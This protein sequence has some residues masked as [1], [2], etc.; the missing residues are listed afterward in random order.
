MCTR[1]DALSKNR[2]ESLVF[3]GCC[4]FCC[5]CCHQ[6]KIECCLR[7]FHYYIHFLL[8]LSSPLFCSFDFSCMWLKCVFG[9]DV[10]DHP[11]EFRSVSLNFIVEKSF[12]LCFG[13]VVCARFCIT[14][15]VCTSASVTALLA[16]LFLLLLLLH[17]TCKWRSD[18]FCSFF[19]WKYERE[20]SNHNS[21]YGS[22]L[23]LAHNKIAPEMHGQMKHHIS[24]NNFILVSI[25]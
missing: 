9:L 18:L 10:P 16:Y 12:S 2:L 25:L 19:L 4:S 20:I 24:L 21:I 1:F 15:S 17:T 11:S 5:C 23:K 7:L 8:L 6:S 13:S 22:K 14:L 3:F